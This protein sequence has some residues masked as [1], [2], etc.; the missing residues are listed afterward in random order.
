[1]HLVKQFKIDYLIKREDRKMTLNPIPGRLFRPCE[2][3]DFDI[4]YNRGTC[5]KMTAMTHLLHI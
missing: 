5:D 4:F 1:M 3:Y 2:L